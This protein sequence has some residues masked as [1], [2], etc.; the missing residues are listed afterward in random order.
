MYKKTYKYGEVVNYLQDEKIES[1]ELNFLVLWENLI[2]K[3]NKMHRHNTIRNS[4]LD[5][6]GS[7][8]NFFI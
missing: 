5:R 1:I 3:W 6:I 4:V 2:L 7:E 8:A